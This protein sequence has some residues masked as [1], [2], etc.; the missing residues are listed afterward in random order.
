MLGKHASLVKK[1]LKSGFGLPE[2][3]ACFKNSPSDI[4]KD[5]VAEEEETCV[6]GM[7]NMGGLGKELILYWETIGEP[8][9]L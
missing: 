8:Y 7:G 5:A 2:Y 1:R 6:V 3:T 4:T 9:D